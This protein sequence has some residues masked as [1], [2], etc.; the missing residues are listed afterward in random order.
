MTWVGW[1]GLALMVLAIVAVLGCLLLALLPAGLRVRRAAL[2]TAALND[3]FQRA[4]DQTVW[5]QREH[6]LERATLLRPY[7][8]VWRIVNHPLTVALLES[9]ARRRARR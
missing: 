1:L 2:V 4:F 6:A 7:R 9:Y 8:R 3:D 5:L